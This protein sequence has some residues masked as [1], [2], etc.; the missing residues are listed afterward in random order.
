M[1]SA[2]N[3]L[4]NE[5]D[6]CFHNVAILV[7]IIRD[8]IFKILTELILH[9][10]ILNRKLITVS[11]IKELKLKNCL[12]EISLIMVFEITGATSLSVA[13]PSIICFF[14]K[15]I[16]QMIREDPLISR[17]CVTFVRTLP[18]I[19]R[20]GRRELTAGSSRAFD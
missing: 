14:Y 4:N 2:W 8:R 13:S 17:F 18:N 20:L 5:T 12:H 9:Y 6:S 3:R 7:L 11:M 19:P 1:K 16:R 15:N 10:L